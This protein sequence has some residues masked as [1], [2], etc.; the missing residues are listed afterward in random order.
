MICFGFIVQYILENILSVPLVLSANIAVFMAA[1]MITWLEFKFPARPEW[2]PSGR[3]FGTDAIFMVSVQ[4][5]LPKL[6]T[7]FIAV[8]LVDYLGSHGFTLT[9]LWPSEWPL[10]AQVILMMT[11]AEFLRYWMHRVFHEW[12]PAWQLHAVHHSPHKLYWLSV[13]RFH[14]LE[15]SIQFLADSLPFIFLGVSAEVLAMYLVFYAINGF[16]QHCNIDVKLGWLNYIISG[17]ELHRWHHSIKIEESNN[18]YGN[19]L[20]V[21]DLAFGTF[22]L[23]RDRRVGT[24][25]LFNRNYPVSFTEQMKTPFIRGLDKKSD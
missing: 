25:G 11:S 1:C 17:P 3:E 4:I 12:T 23:P 22:F 9:G 2:L 24:L 5:I 14:P 20:I 8:K 18:N 21:W 6:L 13:A 7:L 10:A 16:F 15:K 19:N